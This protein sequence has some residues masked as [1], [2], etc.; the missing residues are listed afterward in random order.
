M[1]TSADIHNKEFSRHFR[2]YDEDEVDAFLDEIVNDFDTLLRENQRL[3]E[4]IEIYQKQKTQFAE[5][6]KHLQNTLETAKKTAAEV[7]ENAKQRAE[8]MRQSTEEECTNR[9]WQME[10]E[11]K[12]KLAEVEEKIRQETVR[13]EETRRQCR[14]FL[15]QIK[16]LFRTELDILD[17]PG[18][19]QAVG[20]LEEKDTLGKSA[21]A[22]TKEA[23]QPPAWMKAQPRR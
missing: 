14:Q 4:E 18:V 8:E 6:E 19:R 9:L 13:Y 3:R 11:T 10:L 22:A 23:P 21:A 2:G 15:I 16:S 7:V 1:L 17:D 12:Q 20:S 5:M